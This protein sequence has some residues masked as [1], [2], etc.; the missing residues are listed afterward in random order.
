MKVNLMQ[1]EDLKKFHDVGR[2]YQYLKY[3]S[4]MDFSEP[5]KNHAELGIAILDNSQVLDII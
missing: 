4:L 5:M 2:F 3:K 1:N